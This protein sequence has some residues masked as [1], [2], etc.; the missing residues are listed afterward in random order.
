MALV[1][2]LG[3]LRQAAGR[4]RLTVEAESIRSLLAG[5]ESAISPAFAAALYREGRLERDIEIL[6][7]GR[8]IH[9]LGQLDTSLRP[10]D[11]VTIFQSGLR[12]FPGG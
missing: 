7:N 9:Y 4:A 2:L 11:Q 8:H 12:G 1:I 3:G 6:V 10:A 5:L